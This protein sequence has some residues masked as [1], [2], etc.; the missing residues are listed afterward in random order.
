MAARGYVA[1]VPN[2]NA[3]YASAYG[4]FGPELRRYP[5]VLEAHLNG[6][7]R[8][9]REDTDA[10][11]VSLVGKLDLSRIGMISHGHGSLLA[12]Q[13]ARSRN[14][15]ARS[16]SD[17]NEGNAPLIG[18]LLVAPLYSLEGDADVPLSVILPSCDGVAPDLNGQGYYEDARLDKGREHFAASVYLV[19]ANHDGFN[20]VVKT[21]D[22]ES[23]SQ[24]S[25]CKTEDARAAREAQRDFLAQY[26]PDF[27]DVAMGNDE[28][29]NEAGLNPASGA[30]HQLYGQVVQTALAVPGVQRSI[31][32]QP[33][34]RDDLGYNGFGG[35]S[36]VGGPAFV[37]FC[38]YRQPCGRWPLLPGNPSQARF[39]W[40][41]P[42]SAQ[43][44]MP[45]DDKG[46]DVSQYDALHLRAALDPSDYLNAH[47]KRQALRLTLTDVNGR[48]ASVIVDD[49]SPALAYPPGGLNL[50]AW[51]WADHAFLN[52]VRVPILSFRGIDLARVRSLTLSPAGDL[53]GSLFVADVEFIRPAAQ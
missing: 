10:L 6:L 35:Y 42:L 22:A 36:T 1:V 27:F 18:I 3:V 26:A 31:V 43:W 44:E 15:R 20:E 8:A 34:T 2:L 21:D 16:R 29:A 32:I 40:T 33:R 38:E 11:D 41:T 28:S 51:G 30:P 7:I 17:D 47:R 50:R 52:S 53:S 48:S 49:T 14:E 39:A 45:L 25:G 9:N 4:S 37:E 5:D 13:S 23:L 19:G 46:V 24:S 12:M